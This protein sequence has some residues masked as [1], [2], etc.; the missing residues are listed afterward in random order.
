MDSSLFFFSNSIPS[1][2]TMLF[3][4]LML[5]I[6]NILYLAQYQC[7]VSLSCHFI[8]NLGVTLYT[9]YSLGFSPKHAIKTTP[10]KASCRQSPMKGNQLS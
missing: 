2:Y 6:Y 10:L 5:K 9:D 4:S 7:V 1:T 8:K 3:I